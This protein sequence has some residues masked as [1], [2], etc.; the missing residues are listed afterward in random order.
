MSFF[1][2]TKFFNTESQIIKKMEKFQNIEFLNL[3]LHPKYPK[4]ERNWIQNFFR[5]QISWY[6]IR[7][8]FGYQI[9][10]IQNPKN[11]KVS[12]SRS[13]KNKTSHSDEK[14]V[15]ASF[16]ISS[17]LQMLSMKFVFLFQ[18]VY[19]NQC[20]FP[21]SMHLLFWAIHFFEY[22][23]FSKVTFLSTFL[24]R[25]HFFEHFFEQFA[26]FEHFFRTFLGTFHFKYFFECFFEYFFEYLNFWALFW[27]LFWV[28]FWLLSGQRTLPP[29]NKQL[30][31]TDTFPNVKS[32]CGSS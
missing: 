6:G 23:F 12:K 27:V 29:E 3:R 19:E 4:S 17:F 10:S 9:F 2:K 14:F 30:F 20:I 5:Y 15:F 13:F 8:F 7:Y 11:W 31:S 16:R 24:S 1:F 18:L 26:V 21:F 32:F 28:L 25:S 22:F